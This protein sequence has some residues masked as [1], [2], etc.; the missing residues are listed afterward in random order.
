MEEL[1]KINDWIKNPERDFEQGLLLYNK[2]KTNTKFDEY[3]SA[4]LK[5]PD[6]AAKG[7][8]L[9]NLISINLRFVSDPLHL[10]QILAKQYPAAK[11]IGSNPTPPRKN[12]LP[13]VDE[14][15]KLK[16]LDSLPTELEP[17]AQRI[18]ELQ[19]LIGALHAKLKALSA[20]QEEEAKLIATELIT[21][22]DEKRGLWE[23][24]DNF[25]GI[26]PGLD[27]KNTAAKE[28][29]IKRIKR[30]RDDLNRVKNNLVSYRKNKK[31]LVPKNE[32]TL[33]TLTQK[34]QTLEEEFNSI[35]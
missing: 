14:E 24:I 21:L 10:E 31:H 35:G 15:S 3:F 8:L 33:E 2:F 22:D 20:G 18:R 30:T 26:D 1:K 28:D 9:Q 4:K 29:L 17:K 27:V 23:E 7:L 25:K 5:D 19:P 12:A 6:G 34:L 32:I 13:T 16:S 11:P